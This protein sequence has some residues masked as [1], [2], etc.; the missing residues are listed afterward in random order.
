MVAM[1]T[2]SVKEGVKKEL[3]KYAAELQMKLKSRVDYNEAIRFLL[4]QRRERNPDLLIEAS[5][6]T[7]GAGEAV[8]ALRRER[9]R[10]EERAKRRLRT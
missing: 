6:P 1:T 3:L 8:D 2:I 10:D 9:K 5:R 7:P 4:M